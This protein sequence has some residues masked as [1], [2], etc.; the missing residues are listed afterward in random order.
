MKK[1]DIKKI[2]KRYSVRKLNLND[3]Q[4]IYTF[5]KKNTQYY[6][7]CGKELSIELIEK[8]LEITPPGISL[9]QKYY[10]GFWDNDKIVAVMDLV[11]GYPTY[12]YVYIG[13]FMMECEL[14]GNGIGSKIVSEL[15]EYLSEQGFQKCQLG[16]DKNNIIY[17][18]FNILWNTLFTIKCNNRFSYEFSKYNKKYNFF[19][20]F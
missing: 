12:D 17:T 16:I 8:D 10:V 7:Y 19:I 6:K 18:I 13:F 2:S 20:D 9:E 1:I 11:N 5:C 4:M 3:V 14:Q 15:L